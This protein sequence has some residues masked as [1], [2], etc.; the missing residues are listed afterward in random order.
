M[1]GR[2][3]L[4]LP[5]ILAIVMIAQLAILSVGWV[6]LAVFGA[7]KAEGSAGLYWVLLTIGTTVIVAL[8][9]GVVLYLILSIKAINLNRRQSNFIDSVTHE[10]KSPIASMKLYLQTLSRRHVSEDERGEFYRFMLEDTERL[11][12]LISQLL[13]AGRLETGRTVGEVEESQ[14]G[15]ILKQCAADVCTTYR[16]S[17]E[18]IDWQ[19]EPCTIWARP[20]DLAMIFRNLLD[21]A[22]K[23]AGAEPRVWVDA[24][25]GPRDRVVVR[26][27]D[28]GRGIPVG[29]R[30]KVF[31]RF[32]RLGVELQREKPGTGLGLYIVRTL[33]R[34][35]RGR[36]RLRSREPGPGAVFEVELPRGKPPESAKPN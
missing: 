23:Y 1:T 18:V 10:L 32:E 20:A 24:R 5:I 27:A 33:V 17:P 12:R 29:L 9:A 4:S 8:A 22:V 28:N 14:L 3:S 30:R 7:L 35:L 36:V 26:I 6:L 16:V 34:Q 13:D 2:R 25:R 21:N 19:V 31:G 15:E 11:D